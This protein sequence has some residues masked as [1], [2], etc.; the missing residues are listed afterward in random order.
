[1]KF[2]LGSKTLLVR[3]IIA[4][5]L[6]I[7]SILP[8]KAD[9]LPNSTKDIKSEV[10]G[11]YQIP[12]KL[13]VYSRP[14]KNSDVIFQV[15]WDYK[16]F[17]SSYGKEE[18]FFTILIQSKELAYVQVTDYTDDWT[19]IVYDKKN[20]KKGWIQSEEFRFMSWRSFYNMYG[21]KY[22]LYYL[23]NAPE[24]VKNLHGSTDDIS[25]V[26][27]KINKPIK[28]KL[29]VVKGNWALITAI[30]DNVGK[31]GYIRWRSDDG[32]IYLFPKIK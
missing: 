11:L 16:S 4:L 9:T 21:R 22:G 1:M 31:T 10:I 30:E 25:A 15:N 19:E 28:I 29:T 12:L 8:V 26:I 17:N 6:F 18:D 14:D 7:V 2:H 24:D 20:Y 13:N 32:E 23:K 27:Q 3:I 5:L